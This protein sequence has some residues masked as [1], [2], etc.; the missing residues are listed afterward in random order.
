MTLE[1]VQRLAAQPLALAVDT[2]ALETALEGAGISLPLSGF[3]L[4]LHWTYSATT[5]GLTGEEPSEDSLA[6]DLDDAAG[7]TYSGPV[8]SSVAIQWQNVDVAGLTGVLPEA[9]DAYALVLLRN[10][11]VV[12]YSDEGWAVEFDTATVEY[13]GTAYVGSL[14]TSDVLRFALLTQELSEDSL[15]LNIVEGG[16][17]VIA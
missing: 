11:T 16:E 1:V 15:P 17:I 10:N 12:G 7:I 2:G 6:L 9:D 14:N 13:N 5:E 8:T 3:G 4:N